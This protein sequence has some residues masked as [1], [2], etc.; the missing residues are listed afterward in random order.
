MK[1]LSSTPWLVCTALLALGVG[2]AA[3]AHAERASALR[4]AAGT[5]SAAA[6]DDDDDVDERT[7]EAND[8]DDD[9]DEHPDDDVRLTLDQL[10]AAVR[11]TVEAEV[12]TGSI[13]K[14]E[15]E[16]EPAGPEYEVDYAR[17]GVKYELDVA[18]DGKLLRSKRD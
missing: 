1:R 7:D 17:E 15:R 12:G 11:A 5:A 18:E 2:C 6:L 14:I 3:E 8:R 13:T 16:L 10:P 4:G 9:T